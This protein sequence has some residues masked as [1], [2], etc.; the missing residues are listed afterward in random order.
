MR[1]ILLILIVLT[2]MRSAVK[3]SKE[4]DGIENDG[5]LESMRF[6]DFKS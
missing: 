4:N 5:N 2:S 6:W 3:V 1:V